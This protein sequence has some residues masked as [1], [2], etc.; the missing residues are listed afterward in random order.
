M[1]R[2]D[3][4]AMADSLRSKIDALSA[5]IAEQTQKALDLSTAVKESEQAVAEA[6]KIRAEETAKN[7]QTVK[8]AKIAQE[9][10]AQALSVLK[11]FYSKASEAKS[12][13]QGAADDA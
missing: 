7:A 9:A 13:V 12:F 11:E 4:S 2:E 1:T 5:E 10:V 8:D 3:K 6:K